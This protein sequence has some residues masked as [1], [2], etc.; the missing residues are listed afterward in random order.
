M[1]EPNRG[2]RT[3]EVKH[4]PLLLGKDNSDLTYPLDPFRIAP[5]LAEEGDKAHLAEVLRNLWGHETLQKLRELQERNDSV[6]PL[7]ATETNLDLSLAM[8]LRD[9]TMFVHVDRRRTSEASTRPRLIRFGDWD[10]KD[11]TYKLQHWRDVE[12]DLIRGGYYTAEWVRWGSKYYHSPTK[13]HLEMKPP[14]RTRPP[15]V[16]SIQDRN[17][18]YAHVN[19][20][21]GMVFTFKT[22]AKLLT[23]CLTR[24]E[25]EPPGKKASEVYNPMR[26]EPK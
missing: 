12:E 18:T 3:P 2:K 26:S 10:M 20:T 1:L 9:C 22:D 8:T 6:G 5:G 4:C 23:S 17:E 7:R 13:C 24:Y 19:G 25:K 11:P 14:R 15:D 16:I 21:R